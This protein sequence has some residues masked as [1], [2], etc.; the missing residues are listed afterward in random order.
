MWRKR[1]V[2]AV[3]VV[4]AIVVNGQ[5]KGSHS[6]TD[7][8]ESQAIKQTSQPST[9]IVAIS[10]EN[11]QD[12][13]QSSKKDSKGYF[14]RFAS[15]E[16]LPNILLVIVGAFGIGIAVCTLRNIGR[17]TNL[18]VVYTAA[19][20]RSLRAATRSANAARDNVNL[21]I[22][23][24]RARILVGQLQPLSLTVGAP[25]RVEFRLSYYGST[26]AF[27]VTS[28]IQV[29]L[30]ESRDSFEKTPFPNHIS[31]LPSIV[32][33]ESPTAVFRDFLLKPIPLDTITAQRIDRGEIFVH[34]QALVKYMDFFDRPRE[35]AFHYQWNALD[36]SANSLRRVLFPEGWQ[37]TGGKKENYYT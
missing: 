5:Q 30:S 31:E 33:P 17:Q 8:Q 7:K 27:D 6:R 26:P 11:T 19:T 2:L 16:N 23:K 37:E 24:E 32:L 36:R 28:E 20:R 9:S 14:S 15:P 13:S 1:I 29:A 35:T 3:I 22:N 21:V 12:N 18:L 34:V 4:S 10:N 25:L